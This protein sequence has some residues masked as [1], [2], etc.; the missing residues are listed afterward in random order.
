MEKTGFRSGFGLFFIILVCVSLIGFDH[1]YGDNNRKLKNVQVAV[2]AKWSGTPILLE[3]GEL[4][5]KERKDVFW[6]FIEDWLH[7]EKA[8]DDCRTARDCLKKI[9]KHASSFISEPLASLLEF[10]LTLR[11]GSPRLV[12]YRQLAEESLSSFPPVDDT[13]NNASG[14][15]SEKNGNSESQKSDNML[16]GANPKS[17]NGKCCWVDTGNAVFF[18]VAELLQWLRKQ[19][20]TSEDSQQQPELFDFDHVYFDSSFSSPVAIL[21]GALGTDCFKEFH[22]TLVQAAKEGK[23]KYVVRPVL[24]SG[25]ESKTSPCGAVGTKD[26]VSLG[27]YGV[28]LALKNMEYKAMD[29]S[30]IKKGVTLEDPHMDDLSQDVRGFIF[31]KILERK[32]ELQ[33]EVMA[34]RDY[35]LGST[36]SDTLD[37]WQLKDLGHQTAQRIV[38]ASDPLQSMQEINQNFPSIVSS[39]SRMKLNDSIKDEIIAN[40]RMVPPGKS[41]LALNGASISIEDIDLYQLLDLVHQDLSLAD[42]FFKLKIPHATVRKLL[43]TLPPPESNMFRIDFRS[44]HVQYL[45][46]L[47]K[48]AMYKRWRNN[49]NEI[50]MPVFPG[51]LRYIRKNLFHAVYVIDPS[52]ICG[53]ESIDTITSLYENSVPMRFGVILY[54]SKFTKALERNGGELQSSP[55]LKEDISSL[56]I[57]LFLYIKENYGSQMAFQF[58][59]NINRVR[60]ESADSENDAPE[61][62]HVEGAFVDTILPKAKSPPQELLLKL[63]KDQA[64]KELS[65]ESSMTVFKLG[66]NKKQCCLLMNG[67]V[68]DANEEA[69]MNAMNEELPKIQEQ[70]YYGE[71]NTRTDVLDKFLSESGI[72]RYNPQ[73]IYEGKVK[74]RYVS[75]AS[76]VGE[77]SVF[78]D[79]AYLHSS[80]TV[81]DVKPVT[82]ILAVDVASKNWMR[83]LHEGIRYLI[84]GSKAARLG[85]LFTASLDVNLPKLHFIKVFE[86]TAIS[87]SHKKNVL[88]F[89]DQLCSFY[90]QNYAVK[91]SAAAESNEFTD[92]VCELA[93]ANGLSSKAFRSSITEFSVQEVRKQLNK[94]ANF[95]YG[96]LGLETSANAVITNGRVVLLPHESTFLSHDLE[97]L[98]SMEFRHRIKDIGEI[99]EEVNWS[100]I[101]PDMLTSKF[102]SDIIMFVSSSMAM[103]DRSSQGARFEILNTEYSGIVSNTENSTIHIDAVLDPLSSSGQKLA[104]LLRVLGKFVQPS[105]RVVLN[106]L[107]SV[108]DLPLKNYYRYVLPTMDDFS[109]SDYT[110]YG[111]K[112]FFA[113]MP[114]SKT[115]TMNLDV[116]EPWLVEPVVAVHDLDNILLENL[117]DTRTLQAVF[118]LEALVLTGHCSEK[119]HDPPRGLQL[120][121]GTKSAPHLVDTLVMANLGYWQ[122]K[123]S[124]GVW[125]L[126]L[127]P[128]RSSD[129][130]ALKEGADGSQEKSL[131]KRITMHDLRGK[132]VHLEVV[133]KKGKEHEKL[134]VSADDDSDQDN[135]KVNSWNSNLFKWASGFLGGEGQS[136]KSEKTP[137]QLGQGARHGKTINIFS[138]ASGHLYERFTKIMILSVLKNTQ[139]PVKFWFIKNYLSPQFK[140]VIPHMAREYGF[141]Y[142]LITYKWPT[143]LHKQTEKQRIIWAYKI[144]FLDVIFP[145]SLEKVIFVDADQIVR[146]DMGELYDM[147]LKG[148]PLAY[149]PFCDNNRDMDGYRFW[150]QG[151]WKDHLRGK[152]YHIS[153]LYVVDLVKFRQTAAGDNLRVFYETLSKDPNSLSNLDQDLPNYAQHMVPIFSLPQEWLW[154]E[155]WCGNSTKSN[156]KTIDLCNN[157]MTKEPK[158]QGAKRIVAEWPELDL[159]ARKFTAKIL[160]EE[161]ENQEPA[162]AQP[163]IQPQ[164]TTDKSSEDD[165][166]PKDEL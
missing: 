2:K 88:K 4:L 11:S 143:W 84:G 55:E 121:L 105:L 137:A 80:D 95:L 1:A 129:I 21:Y 82:N 152:P 118:D 132:V 39:L 41:L 15:V 72:S 5:S 103:R 57:R 93:E 127:A 24:P 10:S 83:L 38:H 51:Q 145:L 139:R 16:V 99:I 53:L 146:A 108:V 117:G 141:E 131:S 60:I 75:L 78:N 46:D 111:P 154:C 79:V 27:G 147:N 49:L 43:M 65:Q 6:E 149:T 77:E 133:K 164:T 109:S 101:D 48:D 116:P 81:D 92:K 150:R 115:L 114:L 73:I 119:D 159:E 156:A 63:E 23:V 163:P 125:Y 148:K 22:V 13:L 30:E 87:Y 50:L 40:Q 34:F 160:G 155:S 14:E 37:V 25:C 28:E 130:Y 66:L 122:M 45:N 151:F 100:D 106:P 138:I 8:D 12:L 124:P 104:S 47:E 35:L 162:Q 91:S 158:L 33:S 94:V 20:E 52:T 157:P 161:L 165:L 9:S 98:E 120:I 69:L 54:S 136:K 123:V 86:F 142:E 113:N 58:L 68:I 128:G 7:T 71:I 44:S 3:A 64:F 61:M 90:E 76:S 89:L 32:P 110:V 67:L 29:D 166:E 42:Q 102:V 135:N 19:P 74:P 85:V 17:P 62:H 36:I 107:S 96:Q 31:S 97:L 18:D 126:Q 70:V 140:D 144:L 134:L 112:A 26:P 56:I 59:S 153:A